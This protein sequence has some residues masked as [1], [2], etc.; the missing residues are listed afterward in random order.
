MSSLRELAI[1][2]RDLLRGLPRTDPA[3]ESRLLLQK[4]A[5]L[6]EIRFW[7]F[8]ESSVSP[9]AERVFLT[10]VRRR[11]AGI[12][13]AYLTGEREFWSLTFAVSPDVLVPRPETELLVEK[14]LVFA[15]RGEAVIVEI[16]TGSGAVAVVLAK[17][18]PWAKIVAGDISR[19]ALETARRNAL[20]HGAAVTFV[21]SDLFR[22]LG[23]CIP[24]DGADLV[25]SN[26]PYVAEA[27]WP[28]L[29]REVRREPR[30]ALVAGPTGLE[31]IARLIA[32][33]GSY[34]KPGGRLLFEVGRGQARRALGLF[35]SRWDC[36]EAFK[37]LR[38]ICRVVTARRTGA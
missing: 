4:A 32:G 21:A 16:G 18:L 34:L 29:A 19:R 24:S 30:R 25:V 26:P 5:G 17:E 2:G 23:G 33:A 20:R 22:S 13:L 28:R 38:G 15:P 14:A 6:D 11:R 3:L 27:E 12:P 1:R 31:F 37:D 7:A 9:T 35:D 36:R 10:F 8:P